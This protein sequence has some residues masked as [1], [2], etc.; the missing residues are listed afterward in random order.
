MLVAAQSGQ[1]QQR[2]REVRVLS[3]RA[4]AQ[5]EPP[6]AAIVRVVDERSAPRAT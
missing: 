3:Q 4:V 5:R 1:S 2:I 6:Q